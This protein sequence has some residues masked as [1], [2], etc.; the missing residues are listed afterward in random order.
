MLSIEELIKRLK[1]DKYI[2]ATDTCGHSGRLADFPAIQQI[3]RE[4]E[5]KG[6]KDGN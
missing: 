2:L 3:I 1:E 6:E 5:S 4:L